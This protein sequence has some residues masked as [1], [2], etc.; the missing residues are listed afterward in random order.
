MVGLIWLLSVGAFA[1][2]VCREQQDLPVLI[3]LLAAGVSTLIYF[4]MQKGFDALSQKIGVTGGRGL[5]WALFGAVVGAS[6][7]ISAVAVP[8][9]QVGKPEML[10][11]WD[12]ILPFLVYGVI[13]ATLFFVLFA[14]RELWKISH[15][16][17]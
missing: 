11:A 8:A 7:G 10:W 1:A 6:Y 9:V 4:V 15:G 2:V 13:G 5:S 3:P 16:K 12:L 17:F 14:G